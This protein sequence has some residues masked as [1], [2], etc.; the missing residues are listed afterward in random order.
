MNY[1]LTGKAKQVF[2][3]IEIKARREQELK[4]ILK[5]R[6]CKLSDTATCN[7]P[8]SIPCNMADCPVWLDNIR[9]EREGY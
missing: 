8:A 6:A 1:V 5:T 4:T 3:L 2:R 7:V 9:P